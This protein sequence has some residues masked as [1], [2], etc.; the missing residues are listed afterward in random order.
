MYIA[1]GNSFSAGGHINIINSI[2]PDSTMQMAHRLLQSI[3][4]Q[5]PDM[6]DLEATF[7]SGATGWHPEEL[8]TGDYMDDPKTS[9]YEGNWNG[10]KQPHISDFEAKPNDGLA[11]SATGWHPEEP[12][13]GNSMDNSKALSNEGNWN[14]SE[15]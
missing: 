9:P 15:S 4:E 5:P 12:V 6:S 13:I 14:A 7:N 11:A 2:I 3:I 1:T 10:I 8:V